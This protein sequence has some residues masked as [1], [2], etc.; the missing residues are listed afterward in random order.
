M[1]YMQTTYE[2][3][4]TC[5]LLLGVNRVIPIEINK[6]LEIECLLHSLRFSKDDFVTGHLDFI[7]KKFNVKITRLV[8]NKRF[9]SFI[10]KRWSLPNVDLLV[11]R[12]DLKVIDKLIKK[13]PIVYIDS[14]YLFKDYHFPHFIT[15]L[16][17]S[18][19]GYKIFDTWDGKE[20]FIGSKVLSRSISSLRNHLKICPQLL[21]VE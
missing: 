18:R 3:C 7:V 19:K 20:K 4:L 10:K 21:V 15:I 11:N 16:D 17:K 2:T 5:S 13:K 6:D 1:K 12:I 8:D 9:Y 14:Y